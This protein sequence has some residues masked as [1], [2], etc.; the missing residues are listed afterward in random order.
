MGIILEITD[1]FF[2]K[3]G[4]LTQNLPN[5]EYREYQHDMAINV[6]KMLEEGGIYLIE[7]G[8]GTGKTLAYLIPAIISQKRIIISTKTKNLQEQLFFK[9][10]NLLNSTFSLKPKAIYIKGRSNYICLKKFSKL[11]NKKI[12]FEKE[13]EL[14]KEW[15]NLTESGDLSELNEIYSNKALI[16][17]ISSNSD[18]CFGTKCEFYKK[19]F[20]NKLRINAEKSDIIIVNHHLLFSDLKVKNTG[21]GKVLPE[22][23]FLICDEAHSLEDIA[24]EHFGDSISKYQLLFFTMEIEEFDEKLP[25]NIKEIIF[26]I[27]DNELKGE[28]KKNLNEFNLNRLK[29]LADNLINELKFINKYIENEAI[30]S[31]A[32]EL[33]LIIDKIFFDNSYDLVK[34]VDYGLKNVT[35]N[36]SPIQID[37]ILGNFL[38]N[39]KGVLLTS[40]TLSISEN[41]E[42]IKSRFGIEYTENEK[43]YPSPFNYKKQVLFFV[44]NDIPEPFDDKFIDAISNYIIKLINLTNGNALILFT[45]LKNLELVSKYVKNKITF[46]VFVQGESSNID[47]IENFKLKNNSVLLGSYSFWEGI[48]IEENNLKLLIIDKLPFSPPTDPIRIERIKILNGLGKNSFFEYQI[49]EAIM[50]LKQGFGRLIRSTKHK[51]IFA[52]FD[53]RII[54]KSYGKIFIKNL[55]ELE[56]IDSIEKLKNKLNKFF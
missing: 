49:P 47:L 19:C 52:L 34:W 30:S 22:Y 10:L 43:I 41:F 35:I 8:T 33:I 15:V 14:I 20:I 11:L 21:F 17:Q 9:D 12:F 39:L 29:I 6:A 3:D 13:I 4:L 42:Y 31:K 46:P 36:C 50:S 24:T 56:R 26:E 37:N 38:H 44:P 7:S 25:K 54:T 32:N 16:N 28:S 51:G 1:S 45:S 27:F 2:K 48:D 55:P 40:A 53:K 18:T 23:K 5:F